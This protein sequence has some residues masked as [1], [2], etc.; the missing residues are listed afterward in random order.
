M[1]EI[2]IR[3]INIEVTKSIKSQGDLS[4][5]YHC[6]QENP[7]SPVQY[8][9]K[10][11]CCQGCKNV[12]SL[13]KDANLC[14]YYELQEHPG[15]KVDNKSLDKFD[16]LDEKEI[17]EKI[18]AFKDTETTRVSFFI[19]QIHCASC[20]WL[21]EKLPD[22]EASIKELRVDFIQKRIHI[23]FNH[24]QKSL[25]KIVE[26]ITYLG[27][28]PLINLQSSEKAKE[29]SSKYNTQLFKRIG[30]AGF[31]AGNIM[32]SSLP[33]YFEDITFF[34]SEFRVFFGYLNIVFSIPVVFYSAWG[35]ISGA[36]QALKY[37][38]TTLDVPIALGI[39]SVFIGSVIQVIFFN[40]AGYFDSLTGLVFLLL[41]GKWL[42]EKTY[43][44]FSYDRDYTSYFPLSARL[45]KPSGHEKNIVLEQIK[46][47]DIL[48][49][50]NLELIPADGILIQGKASIDYSFVTGE[51]IPVPAAEGEKVF[52]GGRLHGT[53][54]I[55]VTKE[56]SQSHFV[57][58]WN[59]EV[60]QKNH[61]S[62]NQLS[63]WVVVI[64]KYFTLGTIF[65]TLLTGIIWL[66]I[67][68]SKVFFICVSVLL[69]ACPCA[70]ALAMPFG[71]YNTMRWFG[72]KGLYLKNQQ[73]VERLK[74]V[75][76]IVFD[77]TGT[78]TEHDFNEINYIGK[79]LSLEEKNWLA[80]IFSTSNHPLSNALSKYLSEYKT[81]EIV[82]TNLTE[83]PG[84]GVVG[85]FNN[86]D[87][88]VGSDLLV[89]GSKHTY[90]KKNT[91]Q[92]HVSINN[93]YI[94]CFYLMNPL[95]EGVQK[96]IKILQNEYEVHILSGD[97]KQNTSLFDSWFNNPSNIVFEAQPED[98]M[99]YIQKLQNEGKNV[100]MIGDGLND[101]G[102]L[103]SAYVGMAVTENKHMFTPAC[104][105]IGEVKNIQHLRN[106][107]NASKSTLNI[108]KESYALSFIYNFIGIAFAVS[109][110]L[111]PLLAA[112]LMPLSSITVIIY[113][114]IRTNAA[115]KRFLH[116][117]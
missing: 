92:V 101:S 11:F 31:F 48:S 47:N 104:D 14:N 19:P 4:L 8:D 57:S 77:K 100:L 3:D 88:K 85:S 83:I 111:S 114:T 73:V 35:Y 81:S 106:F 59:Q 50:K 5:C 72:K 116:E 33:E 112:V 25:R 86:I 102:A 46:P 23:T 107:L 29:S 80:H 62:E 68:S 55:K 87:I 7:K 40:K 115:V 20:I 58:L 105:I 30:V 108:V 103:A 67:D 66:F 27:Y 79:E 22:Y 13:L 54:N 2:E 63:K 32:I 96:A 12:Y 117:F 75:D 95:R 93:E 45:I 1:R 36:W 91:S 71:L 70:L 84:K 113:S 26:L 90:S 110:N 97:K 24:T 89:L 42:Q 38:T 49:I 99:F 15:I 28:E 65:L 69:V 60:F 16:F 37:K 74:N 9:E 78:L 41:I 53:G 76:T 34:S 44:S 6:G 56:V 94:G 43:E 61:T 18:I 39:L 51:S 21:L 10:E 17:A 98:K 64:S 109:G 82:F 52:A